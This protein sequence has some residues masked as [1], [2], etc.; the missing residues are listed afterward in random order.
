MYAKE[1][2]PPAHDVRTHLSGPFSITLVPSL[3]TGLIAFGKEKGSGK[4]RRV[5]V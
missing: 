2:D 5:A 3:P 1:Q 4:E